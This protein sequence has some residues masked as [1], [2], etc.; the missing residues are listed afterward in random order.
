[1]PRTR[2][3]SIYS[4]GETVNKK[5]KESAPRVIFLTRT[6]EAHVFHVAGMVEVFH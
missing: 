5:K 3:H 2:E 4:D 1:M 6:G